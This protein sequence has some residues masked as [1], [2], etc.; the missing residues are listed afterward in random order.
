MIAIPALYLILGLVLIALCA[1][2][3]QERIPPNPWY[4]FRVRKT[5]SDSRIWYAANKVAGKDLMSAGAV[6]SFTA[7]V[8][9]L[10]AVY[11]PVFVLV[12]INLAAA[13]FSLAVAVAHSLLIVASRS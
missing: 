2:L 13:V 1:P 7:A 6:I 8:T 3:V 9:W 10:F 11:V 5:M 4:G 12:V